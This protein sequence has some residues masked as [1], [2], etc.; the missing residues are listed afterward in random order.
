MKRKIISI[1]L[2]LAIVLT[3]TGCSTLESDFSKLDYLYTQVSDFE[4]EVST[5]MY[6]ISTSNKYGIFGEEGFISEAANI[7]KKY[8]EIISYIEAIEFKDESVELLKDDYLKILNNYSKAF[9]NVGKAYEN[10]N[11]DAIIEYMGNIGINMAE[12]EA[13]SMRMEEFRVENKLTDIKE[14]DEG[15]KQELDMSEIL[16]LDLDEAITAF[17]TIKD[18]YFFYGVYMYNIN[19]T[20]DDPTI[21]VKIDDKKIEFYDQYGIELLGSAT[22]VIDMCE[23]ENEIAIIRL[24]GD[25]SVENSILTIYPS[26]NNNEY[27]FYEGLGYEEDTSLIYVQDVSDAPDGDYLAYFEYLENNHNNHSYMD[28]SMGFEDKDF[29]FKDKEDNIYHLY[30]T[31]SY[32]YLQVYHKENGMIK[33]G[34]YYECGYVYG[35]EVFPWW[36]KCSLV[37]EDG[38]LISVTIEN[39][40]EARIEFLNGKDNSYVSIPSVNDHYIYQMIRINNM[41]QDVRE[42]ICSILDF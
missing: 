38:N 41:K 37:D 30:I 24:E 9:S 42:R 16:N 23:N 6:D 12:S 7:S 26:V 34:V 31:Y 33:D 32:L 3:F 36:N 35:D 5:I 40:L 21:L 8:E 19:T 25:E 14:L 18:K 2:I 15:S 1:I 22:Y 28:N 20:P 11:D 13:F 10:E 29:I 39:P 17:T 4:R 27:V